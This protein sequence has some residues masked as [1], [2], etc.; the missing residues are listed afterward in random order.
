[1]NLFVKLALACMLGFPAVSVAMATTSDDVLNRVKTAADQVLARVS[2]RR[3]ELKA[4]P[5]RIHDSVADFITPYFD[6]ATMTQSAMGKYWPRANQAQQTA[7]VSEFSEL[8]I[9]TY[10]TTLLE[11]SGKPIRYGGVTWSKD[12]K[13]ARVE[14]TAEPKSGAP[15]T[16]LYYLHEAGGSWQ[17]YDVVV[18]DLS[19]VT[20]YRSSF[21]TEIRAGGIDGLIDKLQ[22][23]NEQ[24]GG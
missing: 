21:A 24:L 12:G 2:E 15:V 13:R 14:T 20:N 7:V 10:G 8:L 22:S 19:L 18:E 9:R 16:I 11:Y 17:V 6:F 1:M 23:R 4:H 5:E 3:A